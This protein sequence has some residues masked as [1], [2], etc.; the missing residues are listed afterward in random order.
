MVI[1]LTV[2]GYHDIIYRS[3]YYRY[4]QEWESSYLCTA[5]GMIAVISS[6]VCTAFFQKLFC[7]I[8]NA[9]LFL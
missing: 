4:A 5:I 2:I 3:K 9:Y 8:L 6:E 1:Y 7:F